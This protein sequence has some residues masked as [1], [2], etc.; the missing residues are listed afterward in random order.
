LSLAF[1]AS[2]VTETTAPTGL[3]ALPSGWEYRRFRLNAS[4]GLP[5]KGFLRARV[6][7][8]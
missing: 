3:P 4:N 5:D 2:V 7:Q 8:P 6:S 1:P